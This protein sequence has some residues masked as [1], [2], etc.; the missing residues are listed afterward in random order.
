VSYKP[1]RLV[2]TNKQTQWSLGCK[3]TIPT[4]RPL[5]VVTQ[6]ITNYVLLSNILKQWD[7]TLK[8]A[9]GSDWWVCQQTFLDSQ[10]RPACISVVTTQHLHG[11]NRKHHS[12][13]FH[14][15]SMVCLDILPGSTAC[16]HLP[17]VVWCHHC[18][19][20]MFTKLQPLP[21]QSVSTILLYKH[22]V[23][24]YTVYTH[25][26]H[27]WQ[28]TNPIHVISVNI[29]NKNKLSIKPKESCEIRSNILTTS[30]ILSVTD[31]YSY[32]QISNTTM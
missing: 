11:P 18:C 5:L 26:W 15:S 23:T 4:E 27:M 7:K 6:L 31:I 32:A 1:D 9:S 17:T 8:I 29:C 12:S 10:Q 30:G 21:L 2:T 28:D 20:D 14:C 22:H 3:R 24:M 19:G 16:C 25:K 13:V